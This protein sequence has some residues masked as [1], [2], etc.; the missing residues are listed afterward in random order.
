[1]DNNPSITMIKAIQDF[2]AARHKAI[3]GEIIARL[4]GESTGLLS[5]EDVRQKLRAQVGSKKVLKEIPISAIIGSVNRYQDFSRDFL[6]GQN[7]EEE[8]WTNVELATYGLA[9]LPPI[10]VYQIDQAYFVSD[11]NHRVSVAKL[12]GVEQIQAY[13]TEVHTRVP[14]T[15]DVRP[16]DLILKAEYSDF[17]ED[18]NLDTVYPDADF[19]LTVPG[20][21]QAL[22][23][24]I[25]V[26]RY[27]MGIEQNREIAYTEAV[28]DWYD[29]VYLPVVQIIRE[30]GILRDFQGRTETDLYLWIAD[31]R[32][33]LEDELKAQIEIAVAAD[34][35]VDQY[36]N[37][38]YRVIARLGNKVVKAL[39]PS[40]LET[41]PAPGEWRQSM[42]PAHQVERLFADILVPLNGLEDGWNALDQA[43]VVAERENSKLHGLFIVATGAEQ[44][45]INIQTIKDEFKA[46]SSK[47]GMN[48][49]FQVMSGD[50]TTGICERARW[51][52]LVILNLTYPPETSWLGR[53]SSGITSLVQKCPRPILFTPQSPRRLENPLLA[54]D[55]SLKAQEALFI[56]TYLAGR[57]NLPLQV[58]TIGDEDFIQDIQGDARKYL[59][60]HDVKAEYLACAGDDP[61][62]VVIR[63]ASELKVDL[64]LLGG[65]S[66][67]PIIEVIRGSDVD[68]ILRQAKIPLLICR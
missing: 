42:L 44:D 46:R 50:V 6:P 10:E 39:V 28:K 49:D 20:Q 27:F 55:G 35:L 45:Y 17:L 65:Y 60:E 2:Q 59:E 38:P 1:M 52:D 40:I 24:H 4:K 16:D 11:G 22:I 29:K 62:D 43:L 66:R 36:S 12:L 47:A 25:S 58:V 32:A 67:N 68:T 37:R 26:H 15:A 63:Q 5:F 23:E 53:M 64:L 34:D 19:S 3:L 14:L 61:A 54:Y 33:F 48:G 31:H 51:N 7:V 30:H 8:R 13:V 57:W 9:G 56:S 41:G 18:T 21:Y